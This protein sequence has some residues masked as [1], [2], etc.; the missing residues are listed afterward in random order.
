MSAAMRSIASGQAKDIIRCWPCHIAQMIGVSP[1]T[2]LSMSP[3]T[4]VNRLVLCTK[5]KYFASRKPMASWAIRDLP[6]RL[7]MKRSGDPRRRSEVRL[8]QAM[9]VDDEVAR[10]GAVDRLLRLG[11]PRLLSARVFGKEADDVDL[12]DV[13]EFMGFQRLQFAP[14]HEMQ[15][16]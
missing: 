2:A 10:L 4:V 15:A 5:R 6:K 9:Q 12:G 1:A 11:A 13:A 8:D 3:G 14:E 16:L 7:A